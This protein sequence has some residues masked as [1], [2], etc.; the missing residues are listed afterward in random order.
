MTSDNSE[1]RCGPIGSDMVIVVPVSMTGYSVIHR[2]VI[3]IHYDDTVFRSLHHCFS[4][5]SD[6]SDVVQLGPIWSDGGPLWSDVVMDILS[7]T[8]HC[9]QQ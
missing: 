2:Q 6:K 1:V 7:F 8:L 9:I 5:K 4:T 3:G